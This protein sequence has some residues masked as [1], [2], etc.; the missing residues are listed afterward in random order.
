MGLEDNI[1]R[2]GSLI[3]EMI[4]EE[5]EF[6]CPKHGKYIGRPFT[7]RLTSNVIDPPCEKCK[8]EEAALQAIEDQRR[9]EE[10]QKAIEEEK[11]QNRIKRLTELNIGKR[12]WNESF[13][14]FK[15]YTD[16]L[17]HHLKICRGFAKDPRGRKLVMLGNNG[18]GKNHLAASILKETGGVIHTIFEIEMMLRQSYSGETQEYRIISRLCKVE[19]L[20]IDEIGRTKG[21]K[22][23]EDWL[24]YVIN[25][26][27]E[28][29]MPLILIS[30]KHLK[31]S[32]PAGSGGCPDCLQN[33]IGNDILSRI[34]EDGLIMEFTG[35]DY[36][37]RIRGARSGGD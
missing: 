14:T 26:R 12:L 16:E 7:N 10:R 24:S 34:I 19:V 22:W 17:E 35:A 8:E 13:E 1:K 29:L 6:E 37:E 9:Q 2:A 33:W 36:R 25:K 23:E 31:E 21:G 32:C 11:E 30:N 4:L 27:H 15:P 5:R 3:N 18:T 28:N 20:A